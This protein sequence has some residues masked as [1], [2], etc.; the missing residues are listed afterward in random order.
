[1][2][3]VATGQCITADGRW[4]T[5]ACDDS[6]DQVI[7]FSRGSYR[8]KAPNDN[9]CMYYGTWIK[10]DKNITWSLG[11]CGVANQFNF[12]DRAGNSVNPKEL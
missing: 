3:N 10:G 11:N 9:T 4:K 12:S 6:S 2:K 1:M 5:Q 7:D 8:I